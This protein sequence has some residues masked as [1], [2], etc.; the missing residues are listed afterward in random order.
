[1]SRIIRGIQHFQ[2]NIFGSKK[3]LFRRLGEGQTPHALF[4]TCSDSRIDPSLLTQTDP[5]EIFILRNAG[6]LVPPYGVRGGEAATL[7]FALKQ[8]HIPDVIVCGHSK[9]GAMQGLLAPDA[10]RELPEVA[11]WLE[12]SRAILANLEQAAAA[13]SPAEKLNLA[14]ERNVLLQL[15]HLKTYPFVADALSSGQLRLH[16][17][18]YFLESG[19]VTAHVPG[20]ER[21]MPLEEAVRKRL[22]AAPAGSTEHGVLGDSI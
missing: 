14:I 5:G 20:H 7:E 19:Q 10:L 1:M 4:I 15:E 21:F 12:Y 13:L 9:C 17:W 3:T 11:A 8:L 6:N 2:E 16:G 18:V 22:A